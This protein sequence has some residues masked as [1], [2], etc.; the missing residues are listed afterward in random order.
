MSLTATACTSY[1]EIPN[2]NFEEN[3]GK[4][5]IP[6][7]NNPISS[8]S[9]PLMQINGIPMINLADLASAAELNW[10]YNSIEGTIEIKDSYNFYTLLKDTTVISKNGIYLPNAEANIVSDEGTVF[11]PVS[12]LSYFDL[13]YEITDNQTISVFLPAEN[14]F[15]SANSLN[16]FEQLFLNMNAEEMY[17]YLSFLTVPLADS[18]LTSR[19]SQLPGASRAYRNGTHEGIDWYSGY[20]GILVDTST[21]VLSMSEGIVVRADHNYN[22]LTL[23]DRERLLEIA[24]QMDHTPE[25]ILDELRG[26]SVW[27]QY[28]NGVTVR[29][30][31]LSA[32][33][34]DVKVGSA[35]KTGDIIGYVG[36]SGTS[37]GVAG[38]NSGLHLHSDILIYGH[39]FWEHLE[40]DEIRMVLEKLFP[41]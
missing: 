20:T 27:V 41:N 4:I 30:A 37:D 16:E 40:Q 23:E 8:Y 35:V 14:N 2:K 10:Q 12:M 29:Y 31:H 19:D 32:I 17:N 39:L 9:L 38:T 26:R 11:L 21:P 36:N 25:Y 18:H 13:T 24:G 6:I 28:Q 33:P 7:E 15:E 3:I 34:P 1:E 5:D 22:E